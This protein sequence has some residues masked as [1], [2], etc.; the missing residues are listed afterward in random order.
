M[1]DVLPWVIEH[2]DQTYRKR[3]WAGKGVLPGLADVTVEAAHWR[4]HPEQHTIAE[5]VL[6]MAYWKDAAASQ[7]AGRPWTHDEA[8]DWRAVPATAQGWV[9]ARRELQAAHERLMADLRALPAAR[10]G[11]PVGKVWS[12]GETD[13]GIDLAVDI[14][15]H[16]SYHA[17]QIFVLKRLCAGSRGPRQA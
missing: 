1:T 4:P 9:D 6:H 10:L 15:T 12:E 5:I 14:A 2:C 8:S 13:R 7:L 17:A 16:D 3:N 11:E